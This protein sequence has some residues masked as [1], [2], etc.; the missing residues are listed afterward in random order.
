[1]GGSV[2]AMVAMTLTGMQQLFSQLHF[3]AHTCRLHLA[4][5][6]SLGI[7]LHAPAATSNAHHG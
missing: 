5:I 7:L 2:P 4:R 3:G 6:S 1:M